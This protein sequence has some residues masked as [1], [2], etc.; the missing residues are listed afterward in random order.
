MDPLPPKIGSGPKSIIYRQH[1]NLQAHHFCTKNH[2]S[3]GA[4]QAKRKIVIKQKYYL[5]LFFDD[6]L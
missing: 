3:P 4:Q 1:L 5:A 2:L 6:L